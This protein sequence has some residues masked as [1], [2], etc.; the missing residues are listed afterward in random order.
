[1]DKLLFQSCLPFKSWEPQKNPIEYVTQTM[2]CEQVKYKE[3]K[4]TTSKHH[5][6][7][8]VKVHAHLILIHFFLLILKHSEIWKLGLCCIGVLWL[9]S[10]G[11]S[12]TR[13]LL[14]CSK[15]E[16]HLF[17]EKTNL[18]CSKKVPNSWNKSWFTNLYQRLGCWQ[19]LELSKQT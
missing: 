16:T 11:T 3:I 13:Q 19:T 18:N 5:F 10:N 1:M 14:A 7:Q 4:D 15:L 17:G 8:N 6:L 12:W 9:P 2:S